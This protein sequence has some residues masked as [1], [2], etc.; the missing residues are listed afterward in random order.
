MRPECPH[1]HLHWVIRAVLSITRDSQSLRPQV[2]TGVTRIHNP[3]AAPTR[4]EIPSPHC[5][6]LPDRTRS[7]PHQQG[8]GYLES[9]TRIPNN[10]H[11]GAEAALQEIPPPTTVQEPRGAADRGPRCRTGSRI[12]SLQSGACR[13]GSAQTECPVRLSPRWP[14]HLVAPRSEDHAEAPEGLGGQ[15][16]P[17]GGW[18]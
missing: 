9:L 8:R 17:G 1:A 15:I 18:C 6:R 3:L 7:E 4:T 14:Y 13:Q 2:L 10:C 11:K 16:C 5:A 12:A